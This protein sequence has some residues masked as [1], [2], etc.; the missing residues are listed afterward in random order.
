MKKLAILTTAIL[1]KECIEAS[2]QSLIRDLIQCNKDTDFLHLVHLDKHARNSKEGNDEASILNYYKSCLSGQSNYKLHLFSPKNQRSGLIKSAHLLFSEF[3]KSDDI[4]H[5]LVLEEDTTF[6][7]PISLKTIERLLSTGD[8]S[9]IIH[10][11]FAVVKPGNQACSTEPGIHTTDE[12]RKLTNFDELDV[13]TRVISTSKCGISWNGTFF[14]KD[15]VKK[16]VENYTTV[17]I[18][19]NFPEDQAS[20]ILKRH[21]GHLK[22]KT[23][24]FSE[25]LENNDK[26]EDIV[27]DN[28]GTISLDRHVILDEVRFRRGNRRGA[29]S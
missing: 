8:K 17:N 9:D 1:D 12:E 18:A 11:S 14:S 16:I 22:I 5:C 29:L 23:V 13:Q 26:F 10:F 25:A 28:T 3:L 6:T 27:W 24:Y 19:S 7:R 2:Q 4:E 20:R 21:F 15:V